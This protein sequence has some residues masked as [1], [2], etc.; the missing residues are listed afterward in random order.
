MFAV[1]TQIVYIKFCHLDI[2]NM[3]KIESFFNMLK[4][5]AKFRKKKKTHPELYTLILLFFWTKIMKCCKYQGGK[6]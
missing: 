4:K 2:Y 5:N 6:I 3:S 1:K